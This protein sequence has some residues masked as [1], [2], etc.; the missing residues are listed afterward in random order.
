M[1]EKILT[2][3]FALDLLAK[4]ATR[5]DW[6]IPLA[7]C[8]LRK[9]QAG[10]TK[11]DGSLIYDPTGTTRERDTNL[12]LEQAHARLRNGRRVGLDPADFGVICVEVVGADR[13]AVNRRFGPSY[14]GWSADLAPPRFLALYELPEGSRSDG[15][16]LAD[17][18]IGEF[19]GAV[20]TRATGPVRPLLLPSILRVARGDGD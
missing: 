19:A 2:P 14:G 20:V 18:H 6:A 8:P 1:N 11:I 12:S 16:F 15:R 17:Y 5:D 4:Y 9:H 13:S 10:K 7:D 3:E